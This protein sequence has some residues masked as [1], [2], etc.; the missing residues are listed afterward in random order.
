M[1]DAH[2][3]AMH[4]FILAALLFGSSMSSEDN[5]SL[6]AE[7]P[8]NQVK[9]VEV[10][11]NMSKKPSLQ[12]HESM[13]L[14]ETYAV[15][16]DGQVCA[17]ARFGVEFM[18]KENKEMMYFNMDPKSTRITGYCTDQKAVLSLEFDGGY[19]EFTFLESG[20]Q[21]YVSK[22]RALLETE[23]YC[24]QCKG[25]IY[26]GILNHE[27]LFKTTKNKSFKC[28]SVTSL[29]IAV[30]LTIKFISLQIQAFNISMNNF[31]KETECWADYLKRTLPIA[32]GA[33]VAGIILIAVLV[34]VLKREHSRPGYEQL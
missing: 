19:L 31:G 20:E 11:R 7:S 29:N 30:N 15:K 1:T 12:P 2:R 24:K 34:C 6:L 4:L 3:M 28:L 32:M 13:P 18:V 9:S 25:P 26:S 23:P 21:S 22:L 17:M 8:L 16:K 10:L 33:V 5:N 27:Q 14:I